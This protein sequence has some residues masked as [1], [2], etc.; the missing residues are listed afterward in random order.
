MHPGGIGNGQS[1]LRVVYA[2]YHKYL[3]IVIT[4]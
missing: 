3:S 1:T 2:G 4:D